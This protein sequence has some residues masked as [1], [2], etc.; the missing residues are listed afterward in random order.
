MSHAGLDKYGR[1]VWSMAGASQCEHLACVNLLSVV[2][3]CV[4]GLVSASAEVG[5]VF[6][7]AAILL[8]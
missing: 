2:Y 4:P 3:G 7:T 5:N 6:G 8:W 1:Y